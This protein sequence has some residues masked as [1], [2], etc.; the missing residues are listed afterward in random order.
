MEMIPVAITS[1]KYPGKR[2]ADARRMKLGWELL[3]D[4]VRFFV[5]TL[6][7]ELETETRSASFIGEDPLA[8]SQRRI[9]PD[10]LAMAAFENGTPVVFVIFV[11]V[12]DLLL[13]WSVC[14][15]CWFCDARSAATNE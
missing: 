5:A 14:S 4:G 3:I 7:L 12:N 11:K 9:V 15:R 6:T 1:A 10:V 8:R 2:S 13:H